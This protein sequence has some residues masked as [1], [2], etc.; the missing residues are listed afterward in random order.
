MI[1]TMIMRIHRLEATTNLFQSSLLMGVS[2]SSLDMLWNYNCCITSV[3]CCGHLQSLHWNC[4]F[5]KEF[6]GL[7]LMQQITYCM[8]LKAYFFTKKAIYFQAIQ[9]SAS[10]LI[11]F[12]INGFSIFFQ[13][14]NRQFCQNISS[15]AIFGFPTCTISMIFLTW[16][17]KCCFW[18]LLCY[19]ARVP[20]LITNFSLMIHWVSDYFKSLRSKNE[21]CTGDAWTHGD[22]RLLHQLTRLR[23]GAQAKLLMASS[24]TTTMTTWAAQAKATS[25]P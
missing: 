23:P 19:T 14:W 17:D 12:R 20:T 16:G 25:P 8:S 21:Q 2:N 4:A 22:G 6:F 9:F 18:I 7:L 3:S 5:F 11:L 13:D 15:P 1:C 24:S 10:K